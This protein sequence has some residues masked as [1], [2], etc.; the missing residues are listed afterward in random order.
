MYI[1]NYMHIYHI[2][3]TWTIYFIQRRFSI[4]DGCGANANAASSSFSV[5]HIKVHGA[6]MGPIWGRQVPGGPRV[7]PIN[8]AIWG[9]S[10]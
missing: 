2:H 5:P 7:G 3:L 10:H 8:F 6:N 4:S 1:I 9:G